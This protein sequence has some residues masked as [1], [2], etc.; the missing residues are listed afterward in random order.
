MPDCSPGGTLWALLGAQ[1]RPRGHGWATGAP[2]A[3]AALELPAAATA[4]ASAQNRHSPSASFSELAQ[5]AQQTQ[6]VAQGTLVEMHR[7]GEQLERA[8]LGMAQVG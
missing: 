3:I 1:Q 6:D 2:G 5:V 8:E 7:Q 4:A